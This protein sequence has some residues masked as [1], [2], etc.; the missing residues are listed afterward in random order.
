MAAITGNQTVRLR[1]PVGTAAEIDVAKKKGVF[2]FD[3]TAGTV[4]VCPADAANFVRLGLHPAD[5][6]AAASLNGTDLVLIVQGGVL[7]QTTVADIGGGGVWQPLDSDLTAIAAL[8]TTSFGRSLLTMANAAAVRSTIGAGTSS[9]SG[10]YSALSGIPSS[11][12]AIDGLTPAADRL[13]YYTGASTGAL[14]TLTSF[15]R[16]LLDDTDASTARTTLGAAASTHDHTSITGSAAKL[17]TARSIAATG[18]ATWSV[19]FDGSAAVSAVL[20]LA[21]II[22]AAGPVGSATRVPIITYDAKGRLTAVTDALITPAWASITGKPT[23]LSGY[24]VA[25]TDVT[26][27]ALTGF[28][29]GSNTAILATDSI[30]AAFQKAQ[31][32]ISARALASD[33]AAGYLPINDPTFTGILTGPRASLT[34]FGVLRDRTSNPAHG[35]LY[36]TGVTPGTSNYAMLIYD[37]GAITALQ[38]SSSVSLAIGAATKLT[39][40]ASAVNIGVSTALQM[41]GVDAID[42]SRNGSFVGLNA[43]STIRAQSDASI[44][45]FQWTPNAAEAI[46]FLG[47]LSTAD[48]GSGYHTALLHSN[49]SE[50]SGRVLGSVT[51]GQKVAGKSGGYAGLKAFIRGETYGFG[52]SVGGFGGRVVIA[53][54][55]D[56]ANLP[57]DVASFDNAK[58]T[59]A[60]GIPFYQGV[61]ERIT[62]GGE[63]RF[64]SLRGTDLANTD[65]SAVFAD[66]NGNLQ[67]TPHLSLSLV[68]GPQFGARVGLVSAVYNGTSGYLATS[69]RMGPDDVAESNDPLGIESGDFWNSKRYHAIGI[70]DGAVGA[71][72]LGRIRADRWTGTSVVSISGTTSATSWFAA[73]TGAGSPT[74][75]ANYLQGGRRVRAKGRVSCQSCAADTAPEFAFKIGSTTIKTQAKA[76]TI[77]GGNAIYVDFDVDFWADGD[78]FLVAVGGIKFYSPAIGGTY[79]HKINYAAA[80][81]GSMAKTIDATIKPSSSAETWSRNLAFIEA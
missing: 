47:S 66:A 49:D 39:A 12:D 44:T 32:Q 34:E 21:N 63:G 69:L 7:K 67:K 50:A 37:D 26:A 53:A 40:T 56:N 46:S 10:A 42:S 3:T 6:P 23:T 76:F 59:L 22:T 52:G 68:N 43:S 8:T 16:T 35:A 70:A 36:P 48:N 38:A 54:R 14:A 33:V 1:M 11:I 75:P 51:F 65:S 74:L 29:A 15:A 13:P 77:A 17:T 28:V 20:T 81:D 31:G 24:G 73:G 55:A 62:A 72:Y 25:A 41:N 64:A 57:S 78:G 9:F 45:A 4:A 27:Q 60:A 30:L 18:D 79:E 2:G 71:R 5:A 80:Y 61:T 19:S 58:I